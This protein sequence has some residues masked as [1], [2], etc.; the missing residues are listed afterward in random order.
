MF[1]K[2]GKNA[3]LPFFRTQAIVHIKN[4]VI[5][6]IIVSIVV[7]WLAGLSKYPPGV[8]RCLVSELGVADIIRLREMRRQA[9]QRLYLTTRSRSIVP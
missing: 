9:F 6:L 7:N 8:M 5:V 3:L 2:P 1:F 4:V